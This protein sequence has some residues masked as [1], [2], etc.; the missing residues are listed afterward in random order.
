VDRIAALVS[1]GGRAQIVLHSGAGNDTSIAYLE[2]GLPNINA[3]PCNLRA[4]SDV[5]SVSDCDVDMRGGAQRGPGRRDIE[6]TRPSSTRCFAFIHARQAP[7][8]LPVMH[9]KVPSTRQDE[10][11][12]RHVGESPG[13]YMA[14]I[15]DW[16]TNYS[17]HQSPSP[18][19]HR[20]MQAMCRPRL[21]RT[22]N[23]SSRTTI[24]ARDMPTPI[25]P[26]R[27]RRPHRSN[28][29]TYWN[30]SRGAAAT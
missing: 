27:H 28:P 2:H 25:R 17:R 5:F 18:C 6:R 30:P 11:T 14:A 10:N 29:S 23:R 7:L 21:T 19:P 4:S 12:L 13:D 15:D 24:S 20:E 26:Q 1:L 8:K 16:Q 3:V 9:L 22:T